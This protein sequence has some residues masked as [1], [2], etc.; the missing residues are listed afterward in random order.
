MERKTDSK[1]AVQKRMAAAWE[2][3]L[4]MQR[5][6]WE[7]GLAMQ[8]L[9]EA[10]DMETVIRMAYEAVNRSMPDGRCAAIGVTHAVTDPVSVGEA[11]LAAAARTKD[12]LLVEGEKR[13]RSWALDHAPGNAEGIVYHM[14]T[15]CEFWAD[16]FYML[17]PYLA[18][19]G[20]KEEAIRQF[21]GYW[22]ALYN[23]KNGLLFHIW[24]DA[25]HKP[26]DA[27]CWG[28]G[29]GWCL[30]AI[31]RIWKALGEDSAWEKARMDLASKGTALL[32][33][34]LSY[35]TENGSFHGIL[36]DP[37]TYEESGIAQM[38]AYTIYRGLR[39]G[40]I[41][42]EDR[43][44]SGASWRDTADSLRLQA[45]GKQDACGFIRDVCGAPSFEESGI[46]PEQQS[47]FIM[48]EQAYLDSLSD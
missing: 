34:I 45:E 48:M 42:E 9:Y 26:S 3:L 37:N 20:E 2:V 10:G 32:E 40:W 24:D 5:H 21:E 27:R 28:I 39:D 33:Q 11:L 1:E 18:V 23:E 4:S 25:G 19:I 13:L 38:C 36:D 14:D 22:K 16:S 35:R 15:G 41:R 47:I 30:M 12:P 8:A 7:Q 31:A 44:R 29:N 17:P 43:L 6:S 46:A